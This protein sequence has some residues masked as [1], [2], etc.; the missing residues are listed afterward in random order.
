[1]YA[2]PA[3]RQQQIAKHQTWALEP[4]SKIEYLRDELE[5][6]ADVKRSRNH[7]RI[8]AKSGAE[9]LPQVALLGL[10]GNAS[11]RAR[12][13][14]VDDDHRGFDHGGHTESL[15]HQ[16]EAASRRSAHRTDAGVRSADRHVDHANLVLY[17]AD[18]DAGLAR[19]R[20]HPV[21]HASRRAHGVSAI[22]FH[23]SGCPA[24]GHRRIAAQDGIAILRLGKP[25]RE[26]R[27]VRGGIIIP[28]P[29]NS[30][31]FGH[32]SLAFFLE[33]LSEDFL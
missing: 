22:E 10:G 3:F 5:A 26:S 14:A 16:S 9:H 7:S 12:T 15:A 20:G 25:I 4:V 18:H 17:L 24:H 31:I 27:E 32:H 28:G 6:I 11:G 33:L 23:A 21:Q 13:L 2:E 30:D 29:R 8:V 1:M 19:V